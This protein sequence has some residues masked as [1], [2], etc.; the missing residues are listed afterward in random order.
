MVRAPAL[1]G[2]AAPVSRRFPAG[3]RR[4]GAWAACA[5]VAVAVGASLILVSVEP[6]RWPAFLIAGH[7]DAPLHVVGALLAAVILTRHPGNRVAWL[8]LL[9]SAAQAAHLLANEY[10]VHAIGG[11]GGPG[12]LGELASWLSPLAL[13]A[14]AGPLVLLIVVFPE[15]RLDSRGSRVLALLAALDLGVAAVSTGVLSWPLRGAGLLDGAPSRAA[16]EHAFPLPLLSEVVIA[17]V[18]VAAVTV[19][20]RRF[21]RADGVLRQ[22]LKWF[23]AGFAAVVAAVIAGHLLRGQAGGAVAAFS[24]V[25][26]YVGVYVAIRRHHLY[27]IDRIVSRG[28]AWLLLSAVLAGTY[29]LTATLLG[30]AL[31]R[32]AGGG[33]LSVAGSAVAAAALFTP[34][35]RPL[36]N[37]CDRAF[38]RRAY[39][40]R[41]LIARYVEETQVAEPRPGALRAAAASALE[42]P[43]AEVALWMPGLGGYIDEEGNAVTAFQSG[44]STTRVDRGATHL[45]VVVHRPSQDPAVPAEVAQAAVT[46]FDYA[47]LRAEVLVR[48]REVR[49]SRARIVAAGDVERRRIERDLHDGAQQRLLAVA[50]DLGRLQH[51]VAR[52]SAPTVVK[53]LAELTGEVQA[54]TAELRQLARG[55]VPPVLTERGLVAALETLAERSPVRVD[56]EAALDCEPA[57]AVQTAAYYVAAEGL[58]NVARHAA[59][60][61]AWISLRAGAMGLSVTVD[62]DGVGGATVRAGTGLLGLRDRVEATG[63]VLTVGTRPGGGTRL[64]AEFPTSS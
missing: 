56:V 27:D 18:A 49:E 20:L 55:L 1:E 10:G 30:W 43:A 5:A 64:H 21:R 4:A 58:T 6:G 52:N 24:A 51:H 53:R 44:R 32:F 25:P 22:Q 36:Q 60:R 50:L 63:G 2:A 15:G 8:M 54:A 37:A 12:P 42:D 13:I 3:A 17:V 59:A 34:A 16:M 48:L 40:A 39:D 33:T 28:L 61:H 35:R 19:P 26:G 47:R 62:D 7:A 38:R 31:G 9:S 46:A 23:A 14:A 45:G 11:A 29:A 57:P 41:R